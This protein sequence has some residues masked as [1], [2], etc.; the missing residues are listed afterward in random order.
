MRFYKGDIV[1][2]LQDKYKGNRYRIA[3][4]KLSYDKKIIILDTGIEMTGG[5]TL[6]FRNE[7]VM[8]YRRPLINHIKNLLNINNV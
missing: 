7:N 6:K 4:V 5:F 1:E 8:L 3:M 2:V